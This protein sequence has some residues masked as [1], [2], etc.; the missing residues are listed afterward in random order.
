MNLSRPSSSHGFSLVEMLVVIAVIGILSA[1]AVPQLGRINDA[2]NEAKD[3]RNAQN[4][5]SV[6]HSGEGAGLNLE[7]ADLN[8]T[9][10]L[11]VAGGTVTEGVFAGQFFGVMGLSNE[12]QDKAAQ[13]LEYSDGSL[14]YIGSNAP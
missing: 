8:S 11:I 6:F 4:L 10:D 13:Y 5:A 1:V 12:E 3:K 2:T 14:Q 9:I 7:G